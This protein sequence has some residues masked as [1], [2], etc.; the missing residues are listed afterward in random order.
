MPP[1][2][3]AVLIGM[4]IVAGAWTIC[5]VTQSLAEASVKRAQA[6]HKTPPAYRSVSGSGS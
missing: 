4:G 3:L 5:S 1:S 6:E 2:D